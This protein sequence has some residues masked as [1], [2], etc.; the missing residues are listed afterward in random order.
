MMIRQL[1]LATFFLLN[2]IFAL[3]Q[4][5][6][7]LVIYTHNDCNGAND[8]QLTPVVSGGRTPYTYLWDD[9]NNQNTLTAIGLSP[10]NYTITVTDSSGC[11][12]ISN[13]SITEPDTLMITSISS[14]SALCFGENN[15]NV[16][17]SLSGGTPT[18]NFNWSFGGT[19]ANSNA[20][21]GLHSV[22]I[23]DANGCSVDSMVSV[24]QPNQILTSFTKDS[25]SCQG[26][27]DGWAVISA[28]GG[29]GDFSYSWSNGSDSSSAYNLSAG[30]QSVSITDE[31][32]CVILDSVEIYEPNYILSID[33][34][35][36]SDITC[37]SANNG[38]IAVYATGGLSLEYFKSDGFTT[39]S[40][41]NN[42]F[43]SVAPGSYVITVEDFKG[44][45]DTETVSL[46]QPDSLYIDS[47]IF[48]HVQC[49]GLSNG[50]ID[51]IIAMGGTGSYQF[52]VNGGPVYSNTAYFNGYDAGTY[53]VEVFDDNNCI[54]QDV[55]IIDEPPVLNVAINPSLWN[56][57]QIRCHGDNSGTA[58]FSISGGAAP[59]LKTTT[60]NGDTLASSYLSNVSDLVAG[61]YDFIVEDSYGCIYLESI[62]YNQPDTIIHSFV[63]NHVTCN[64]W[65]NGSL[66]DVV[67]GGVGNPTT[68]HYLW[69][70][71]DT[72]YSLTNLS[73][74]VYGITVTDENGCQNYDQFEINDTNK[75]YAEVDL[76]LTNDVTCFDYCDGE[77]ALNVSGGI[78]NITPNGNAI[79]YYQWNDTLLQTS[80]TAL[81]LCVNNNTNSTIYECVISDAQ[82]CYDTV[83]YSL[84]QPEQLHTTIDLVDP[85]AC[86]GESSGKIKA[87][88]QGGN[89]PPPYT[90]SW[91][92]G[93][94]TSTNYNII[95]G[96]YVV[97]VTDNK[98][99]SD[100]AEIM[101][102]EPTSLS[103]SIS[104]SDVTCFGSDDG[105]ITATPSGGTP[106]P[107]IPPTYYYLWDDSDGQTTQTA[108]G[109]SPNIYT[110]TVTDANGC[111][112][113]SQTV[114]IS[115]PTNELVVTAD[116]TDETCLLNDGSAQ[117]FVL[118][119]VPDYDFIWTGPAG[120][121]NVNSNISNLNPGLY[122]VTVTDANGCEVSTTTTVNGVTEIFLPDNVSLLDTT[123]CLG[124]TITL[125]VQEKPGLFYAWD[126]GSTN[127]DKDVSPTDPV[128]N[129][130]LTVVDPNCL[131][132]YTVE[133][134]VRVTYVENTILNDANTTVGDNPII[135]LNDQ[136]NLQSGNLF[137]AYSWS[138][139]SSSSSI[140]VQP[141]ESTWYSLMVD[142]SGC[143]G[144]DS[145][146]VVLGV[147][148]Y[149]AITP[150]G[151]QMNDVW[152]ILDIENYPSAIVKE[153][154][155]WGEIVFE[156]NGGAA[157]I[158]WDGMFESK[159][160]P[161]GTYYYVIDLNNG[162]DP[163]TGPITIVR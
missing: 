72:T 140:S 130:F 18:Y 144:I 138:N 98:G 123:I 59:Y 37:Y 53:T 79:Y 94:N 128:N 92:N 106:E 2:S 43:T 119:G 45:F 100:T 132:P 21:A 150:N 15:G 154:N 90:Y 34:I 39:S 42:L 158:P 85:I 71:G 91:N 44:C 67:S 30:Y 4:C 51:N 28:V 103:V 65:N 3:G 48:S 160:L 162:E 27:A 80:S 151:D 63:A 153:F 133:A 156:S 73:V 20:P 122:S 95:A 77:I 74:G 1:T 155:R 31:N 46:S 105:E 161:V 145:I 49:F 97:V 112:V 5:D 36:S 139:G 152:E 121:S 26:L 6:Y 7:T 68:Y 141:L 8:G 58:D 32:M 25:V 116:S 14:D 35:I 135:T 40:Q 13:A 69:N 61:T 23:T 33:S 163:Q 52:S 102:E 89:T 54:A 148:P 81:G 41:T 29:T 66:T 136:I 50:S 10:G 157:Y 75:L 108:I 84:S 47:T 64:G 9:I 76:L 56:N 159:E 101:L 88:A 129:Y 60:S 120:F 86:F 142:S 131:N 137:D 109:L 126:D 107:G 57:Y 78:P 147:I 104:E 146:Y 17:L 93:V 115:G 99:C 96:N 62:T 38:T 87:E 16:Y 143:L 118:G 11:V 70:T 125:D 134:I 22:I 114:N 127:A 82:G 113:T 19:T 117:V 124:T 111:T 24:D 83:S 12:D 110:V 149:D 55:I